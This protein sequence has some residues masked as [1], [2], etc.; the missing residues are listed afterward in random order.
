[1]QPAALPLPSSVLPDLVAPIGVVA[2]AGPDLTYEIRRQAGS[3][4]VRLG[5]GGRALSAVLLPPLGPAMQV[6]LSMLHGAEA[7][8][9][10]VAFNAFADLPVSP[11][12][13]NLHAQAWTLLA[14]MLTAEPWFSQAVGSPPRR[15]DGES[16]KSPGTP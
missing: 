8:A 6:H 7:I 11:D 2:C 3:L 1:M 10:S 16:A 13:E 12:F 9:L 4:V 14:A 5:W 15:A